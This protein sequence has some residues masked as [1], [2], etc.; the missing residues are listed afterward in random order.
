MAR[1]NNST[2]H[3]KALYDDAW[4]TVRMRCNNGEIK[5]AVYAEEGK[6]VFDKAA[7]IMLNVEPGTCST[8]TAYCYKHFAHC[9]MN[10]T[11]PEAKVTGCIGGVL[12]YDWSSR[13][14]LKGHMG[15]KGS[16]LL[17]NFMRER[18]IYQEDFAIAECV[19][20]FDETAFDHISHMYSLTWLTV[21]QSMF[22][23]P[24]TRKRKI[25]WLLKIGSL[26]WH[27]CVREDMALV[28]Q[29]LFHMPCTMRGDIFFAAPKQAVRAFK[30]K[31][32]AKRF[33]PLRRRSGK[34]W[35]GFQLLK[36]GPRGRLLEYERRSRD[37]NLHFGGSLVYDLSQ[38]PSFSG[39]NADGMMPAL[40]RKSMRWGSH[41][42]RLL[43]PAETLEVQGIGPIYRH[44]MYDESEEHNALSN[45]MF[46]TPFYDAVA[47]GD[48][49]DSALRSM[50]GNTM[51]LS[52]IGAALLVALACTEKVSTSGT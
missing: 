14:A 16:M 42:H 2:K 5:K 9:P 48:F 35:S 32:A 46:R 52:V 39:I 18:L 28:F 47:R 20:G 31:L 10:N 7:A 34:E 19:Q 24:G 15:W 36:A 22:G 4:K 25:M 38:E 30:R 21:C 12:C 29:Q 11:N 43:M 6:K 27:R 50:A 23:V 51:C 33:M 26:I 44:S 1:E 37:K 13:G 49:T 8:N 45:G 3:N 40:L 41:A 17:L